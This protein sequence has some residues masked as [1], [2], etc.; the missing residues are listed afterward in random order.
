M[1]DLPCRDTA[2]LAASQPPAAAACDAKAW[3]E[4]FLALLRHP[5][6]RAEQES[7][8]AQAGLSPLTWQ[9]CRVLLSR[10]LPRLLENSPF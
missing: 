7:L 6:C 5:P 4:G 1:V 8:K 3:A 9:P 2:C 10:R